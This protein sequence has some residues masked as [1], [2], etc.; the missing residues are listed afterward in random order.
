VIVLVL[1]AATPAEAVATP[2]AVV[3]VV[4]VTQVAAATQVAAVVVSRPCRRRVWTQRARPK[5]A[6]HVLLPAPVQGRIGT[7]RKRRR[8][9][10]VEP[11]SP[12]RASAVA[13]ARLGRTWVK[14][15][16]TTTERAALASLRSGP[17]APIH[18]LA[19]EP[20]VTSC[21]YAV[22]LRVAGRIGGPPFLRSARI[23]P[24]RRLVLG[25]G[26]DLARFRPERSD[27]PIKAAHHRLAD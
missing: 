4:V 18:F 3:V 11:R 22:F 8:R 19:E 2:A 27:A 13:A 16:T 10:A 23:A 5:V 1:L 26:S 9:R 25:R 21:Y 14:I 17:F 7:T 20:R 6:A 24:V 12:R 15:G